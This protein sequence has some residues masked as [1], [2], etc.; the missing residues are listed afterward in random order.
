VS[1][2]DTSFLVDLLREQKKGI[3]GPAHHKVASMG[4]SSLQLSLFVVCELEAGAALAQN[5]KQELIRVRFICQQCDVVYPDSGFASLYGTTL[6]KLRRQGV[7]VATMDLLI[8][9]TALAH[10]EIL[11]TRNLKDF[12]KI[13]ELHVETY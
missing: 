3:H 13:P 4:D 5:P 10:D 1:F 6:A 9:V 2:L 7:T 12:Q 8:G 11:I